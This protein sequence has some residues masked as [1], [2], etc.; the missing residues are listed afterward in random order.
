MADPSE[1]HTCQATSS[2]GVR[3]GDSG[4]RGGNTT[5]LVVG[6]AGQS[7]LESGIVE[8]LGTAELREVEVHDEDGLDGEVPGDIVEDEAKSE[9]LGQV[10]ETE[11]DPVGEILDVIGVSGGLDGAEGEVGGEEEADEIGN[12]HGES[13]DGVK[14][15]DHGGTTK[16]EVR[17][18]HIGALL[19][20]GEHRVLGELL[21]ELA[22]VV[23]GLVLSGQEGG[24]RLHLGLSRLGR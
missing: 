9:A 19:S 4:L 5:T 14:E 3:D 12:G 20:L 11:D 2:L 10:E 24:V 7:G 22:D 8:L 13:V 16:D 15:E 1:S 23:V 17:L 21:V 18:G 6:D